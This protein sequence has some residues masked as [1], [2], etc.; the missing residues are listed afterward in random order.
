MVRIQVEPFLIIN[1]ISTITKFWQSLPRLHELMASLTWFWPALA[2][3]EVNTSLHA[4][5]RYTTK[6]VNACHTTIDIHWAHW[7]RL[8]PE[9]GFHTKKTWRQ[10]TSKY[11]SNPSYLR[12]HIIWI[13]HKKI[14]FYNVKCNHSIMFLSF[15]TWMY[16][17]KLSSNDNFLKH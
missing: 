15:K 16:T 4:Y 14:H 10:R 3:L 11:S 7:L 13:I 2:R 9:S 8:I 5:Y 6:G 12:K 1:I 17:P